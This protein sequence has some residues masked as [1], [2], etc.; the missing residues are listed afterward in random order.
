MIRY[1]FLEARGMMNDIERYS[2]R[3][4]LDQIFCGQKANYKWRSYQAD[5][6]LI[7]I[8]CI[9]HCNVQPRIQLHI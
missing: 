7:N 6:L 5:R 4:Q 9:M 1:D 2:N 8:Y 3:P